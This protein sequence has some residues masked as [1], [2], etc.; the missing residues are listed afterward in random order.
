VLDGGS[1]S[2]TLHEGG[3][4]NTTF[5]VSG[6]PSPGRLTAGAGLALERGEWVHLA[7]QWYEEEGAFVLE[8]YVNGRLENVGRDLA[9]GAREGVAWTPRAEGW[10]PK[11]IGQRILLG[12]AA[13][14]GGALGGVIDELR[15]SDVRRYAADFTP[16]RAAPLTLDPHTL[17]L[18]HFEGTAQGISREKN[19][20]LAEL[21]R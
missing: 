8:T 4:R 13:G 15:I 21:L 16:S 5:A 7:Y 17:A 6:G 20:V 10:R 9:L 1:W 3:K 11:E 14:G 12:R 19:A 18:F 2:I